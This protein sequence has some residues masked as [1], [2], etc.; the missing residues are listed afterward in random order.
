M[1]WR[2]SGWPLATTL[3]WN[4]PS[5]SLRGMHHPT[6]K[7]AVLFKISQRALRRRNGTLTENDE[8]DVVGKSRSP[9]G[10][11]KLVR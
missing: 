3:E 9:T 1:A 5:L 4:A 6:L 8:K 7:Q 2:P 11:H 10:T